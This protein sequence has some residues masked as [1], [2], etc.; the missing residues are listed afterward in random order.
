MNGRSGR[1][2]RRDSE[3]SWKSGAIPSRS[4]PSTTRS[5]YDSTSTR[6]NSQSDRVQARTNSRRLVRSRARVVPIAA[7]EKRARVVIGDCLQKRRTWSASS[8][9][10]TPT[11]FCAEEFG[12]RAVRA[13]AWVSESR[14][15]VLPLVD[16]ERDEI[17]DG[18]GFDFRFNHN[19]L[20][21]HVEVKATKGDE[22]SFDLGISEIEAATSIA[23]RRGHTWRWRIL[24]VRNSFSSTPEI[25]WLPNPFEEGFKK[26]YRLHRGGMV[27]S[28]ARGIS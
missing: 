8:E 6:W 18:H 2:R 9:R 11:D 26:H 19:D 12:R 24:R 22:S 20:R 28:Y 17:S 21:W 23:R 3:G 16:G 27:V 25:D 7:E 13:S 10:C 1:E 5:Y 14:L 4:D 15:K